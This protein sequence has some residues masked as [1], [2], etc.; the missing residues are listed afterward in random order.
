[1]ATSKIK[2][3]CKTDI[4]ISSYITPESGTTIQSA[5][6]MNGYVNIIFL[7][8]K[9]D[10]AEL[11]TIATVASQFAPRYAQGASYIGSLEPATASDLGNGWCDIKQEGIIKA[12][13]DRATQYG[14]YGNIMYLI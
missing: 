12:Y 9:Y 5:K 14:I 6:F 13:Y 10:S 1:M 7:T 3:T 8:P 11:K 2:A 4:D